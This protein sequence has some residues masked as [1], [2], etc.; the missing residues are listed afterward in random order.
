MNKYANLT[1][2]QASQLLNEL[3][4]ATRQ[5]RGMRPGNSL[6]DHLAEVIFKRFTVGTVET[7]A[8]PDAKLHSV[9]VVCGRLMDPSLDL[10]AMQLDFED[11]WHLRTNLDKGTPARS[12]VMALRLTAARVASRYCPQYIIEQAGG[13]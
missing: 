7:A 8:V 13:K 9:Q 6:R 5:E 4:A 3:E 2:E 11:G 12:V 10:R 1:P